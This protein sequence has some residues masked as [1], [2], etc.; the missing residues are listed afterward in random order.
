VPVSGRTPLADALAVARRMLRQD[1]AKRPNARP[2]AVVVSDGLP[3]VPRRPG[4]DALV[5]ALREAAALRRAHVG[6]VVI[7]AEPPGRERRSCARQLADAA[8]GVYLEL[9]KLSP[10]VF[11]DA[12]DRVA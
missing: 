8:G 12:L 10:G 7:D 4:G 11:A 5:D 9:A 1:Q 6:V 2:V 3:N